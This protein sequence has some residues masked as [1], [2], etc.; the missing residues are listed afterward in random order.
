VVV[1]IGV[2]SHKATHTV[3]AVDEVGRVLAEKK[4]LATSEGHLTLVQWSARFEGVVFALEDCRHLTRRLEADLLRAGHVVV[5]VPTRLMA[6]AR[7]SARDPG[8]SD[9]IDAEAVARAALRYP[10]LPRAELDGPAREVKLLSD[11]RRDLVGQR[12]R[13]AAQVRWHLHELDP[14]LEIPSRGLRRKS[15]V[16]QLQQRLAG[17]PGVVARIT[18]DLLARCEQLNAQIAG[19]DAELRDLVRD[20]A[21]SLLA[22]PGCGVLSA[23]VIIGET[24]GVHRFRSRAAFARFTGTAPVPVWSG[25]SAGKVRL[26]R[27]GNRGVNCALHNIAI[28]QAR[29]GVGPGAAYITKQTERGKDTTAALRLLRR[30]LSDTVFTALRSDQ[31]TASNPAIPLP[32]AA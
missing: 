17:V 29:R 6:Q 24:A 15:V 23:A 19:L 18:R 28:T 4:V 27:G 32:E 26:N 31:A 25:A 21:P 12:T 20:L 5:R 9:P 10:D 14:G 30:R 8:K 3:V 22:I 1:T 7:R 2:D 16:A 13:I 11:H